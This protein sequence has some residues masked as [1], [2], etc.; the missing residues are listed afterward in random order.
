MKIMNKLF[1]Q[2]YT[3]SN[4]EYTV[5]PFNGNRGAHGYKIFEKNGNLIGVVLSELLLDF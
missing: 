4:D 2:K 1:P 5:D 3:I